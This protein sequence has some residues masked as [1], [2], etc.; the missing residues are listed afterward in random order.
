MSDQN[1]HSRRSILRTAAGVTIFG[2]AIGTAV[3]RGEGNGN[4]GGGPPEDPGARTI[5][6][7]GQRGSEHATKACDPGEQACWKW[8]LTPGGQPSLEGVG[9]LEV[10]IDGETVTAEPDQ[11]GEG[12]YQFEVCKD[13]GGTVESA[14]VDVDGGGPNAHLTISEVECVPGD[15]PDATHW[16]VDFAEGDEP[17][18]PPRYWP[19]DLMAAL[20]NTTDGV[21]DNTSIR[22]QE[23]DGQL[24]DISVQDNAFD[25]DT[26]D[27]V[28]VRFTVDDDAPE[29]DLHLT[30]FRLPGPFDD[31]EIEDQEYVRHDSATFGGG[32]TGE[33]TISLDLS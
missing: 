15:E 33:L 6:W 2:A 13:G 20:G 14:E 19:D 9:T 4:G 1:Y 10:V 25:F 24:A 28:T 8:I 21:T 30:L 27:E 29:R 11:R 17:P 18:I 22:R 23:T 16:Q 3:G 26:P 5:E 32:D 31:D 12:A 7:D